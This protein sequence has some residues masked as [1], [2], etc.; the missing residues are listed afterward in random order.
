MFACVFGFLPFTVEFLSTYFVPL[1]ALV[2][3]IFIVYFYT[4][5]DNKVIF[6]VGY[7]IFLALVG[8]LVLKFMVSVATHYAP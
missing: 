6:F 8:F 4:R 2:I 7:I 3:S 1:L 5:T